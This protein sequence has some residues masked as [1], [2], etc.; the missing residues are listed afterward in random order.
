M[1]DPFREVVAE[2]EFCDAAAG[3]G[4]TRGAIEVAVRRART[5]N[6]KTI[7]AM[8]TLLL[9]EEMAEYA[10]EIGAVPVVEITSAARERRPRKDQGFQVT[11]LI[12]QHIRGE[13]APRDGHVVFI[14]HEAFLRM[15][16]N[17]PA[18]TK[19]FELIID[20]TFDAVLTRSPFKLRDNSFILTN[21]LATEATQLSPIARRARDAAQVKADAVGAKPYSV[22]DEARWLRLIDLLAKL[23][24][25]RGAF[26]GE[27]AA[28]KARIEE[29]QGR[30]KENRAKKTTWDK[31]RKEHKIPD[32]LRP[33]YQVVPSDVNWFNE[34]ET[35]AAPNPLKYVERRAGYVKE[36]D[37]IYKY[38]EPIASWIL[39]DAPLFT[40]KLGW[41]RMTRRTDY[42]PDRGQITI[43]GFRRPDALAC[44]GRVTLMSALFL[45]TM[46]H[47][48]WEPLGVKFTPS[49]LIPIDRR[50]VPL[51]ART[52]R[53]YWLT[54]E[55]WSKRLRD[56]SGGMGPIFDLIK[57]AGVLDLNADLA[58]CTNKDDAD[59]LNPSL[60]REAF[61]G[62]TLMP[63]NARGLNRFRHMHQLIHCAALNA[64]TPDIVWIE[65]MLGIGADEQR[66]ARCGQEIYQTLMRLSLR[67]LT[68]TD[69]VTLVVM[70]KDVAEWLPQWF[71]PIDQVIVEGI[72]SEGVIIRKGRAGRPTVGEAPMTDAERKARSRRLAAPQPRLRGPEPKR[73]RGRPK[74]AKDTKK[75]RVT[76][77][78]R[79][80]FVVRQNPDQTWQVYRREGREWVSASFAYPNEADARRAELNA[81]KRALITTREE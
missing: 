24:R 46:L 13:K 67:D 16:R 76:R 66:L 15:G 75:R 47:D 32:F 55:G 51:G 8:P 79:D 19:G 9:V 10:R 52:L 7:F 73:K 30:I 38:L 68:A 57:R 74:G 81:R 27:E 77:R 71:D 33:Y 49:R 65:T 31:T 2:V 69:D 40:D 62:S 34:Q 23:T 37:D 64:H 12:A 18:D 45:H 50:T 28:A 29:I 35:D 44:F 61:P 4:K 22:E 21:W 43:S 26:A 25:E 3:A 70:D 1:A 41:D 42:Q 48:I 80:R 11:A 39:Q 36:L 72:D 63:H 14:T 56:R 78:P 53:I 6:I 54:D 59:E 5:D 20:E 60:I 58:I 17:W